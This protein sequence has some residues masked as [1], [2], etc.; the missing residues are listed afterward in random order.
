MK[1]KLKCIGHVKT[2]YQ[3]IEDCP[4]NIDPSGPLCQL[5]ID[6][7]YKEALTGLVQGQKILILYWFE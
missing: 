6:D 1:A 2:S 7:E 4:R 5:H 3:R